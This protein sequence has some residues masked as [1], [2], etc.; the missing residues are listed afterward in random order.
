MFRDDFEIAALV[1]QWIVAD[2]TTCGSLA[3]GTFR[4][5]FEIAALVGQ[6]VVA[7]QTTCGS[8]AD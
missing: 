2:Q 5:D 6:W 3:D 4:D 8:L 7:D 1:G